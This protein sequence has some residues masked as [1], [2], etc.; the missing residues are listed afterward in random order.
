MSLKELSIEAHM[1][2][3]LRK[4]RYSLNLKQHQLAKR[5]HIT[6]QQLSHYER[7]TDNIPPYRLYQLCKVLGVSP[8]FFFEGLGG[9]SISLADQEIWLT[10]EDLKGQKVQIELSN[11]YATKNCTER[12]KET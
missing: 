2:Q 8:N 12:L 4:L 6:S 5:L 7:G 1:G 10:Y 11:L 3:Q 9:V